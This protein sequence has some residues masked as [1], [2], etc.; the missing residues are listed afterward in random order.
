MQDAV[1]F[2]LELRIA[3]RFVSEGGSEESW[4][5]MT[6]QKDGFYN[7][8]FATLPHPTMIQVQ[9]HIRDIERGIY[10]LK[11]IPTGFF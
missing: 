8:D 5:A 9:N 7:R 3:A 1:N 2:P 11:K 10:D 6:R 4:S